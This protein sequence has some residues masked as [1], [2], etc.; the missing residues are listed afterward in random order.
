LKQFGAS[1]IF[2][3]DENKVLLFLRDDCE[4]INCP[5]MWD[6]LGGQI[7]ANET[8]EEC[9]VR[10]IKE[11]IGLNLTDFHLFEQREFSDRI[12]FTFWKRQN[13]AIESITLTEGQTLRWFTRLE[14]QTTPLAFG[15]NSTIERFFE[16]ATMEE[17]GTNLYSQLTGNAISKP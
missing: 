11:E 4:H 16:K 15:F 17:K 13:I 8:P 12:E 1:M 5:N 7:E 2:V 14:A 10:E 6:I 9:I 3:N